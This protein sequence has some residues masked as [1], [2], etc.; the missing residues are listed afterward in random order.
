MAIAFRLALHLILRP[1]VAGM[2]VRPVM[3]RAAPRETRHLTS[4]CG[5]AGGCQNFR[6]PIQRRVRHRHLFVLAATFY[7]HFRRIARS[8]E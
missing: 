8:S 5:L 4:F 7:T 3:D 6:F 1:L 2:G